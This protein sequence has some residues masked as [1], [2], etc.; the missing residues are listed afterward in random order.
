MFSILH[1]FCA[2]VAFFKPLEPV[3]ATLQPLLDLLLNR[4]PHAV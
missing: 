2:F 1:M 4:I 3:F